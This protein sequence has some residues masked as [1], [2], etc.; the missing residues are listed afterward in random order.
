M[1]FFEHQERARRKTGLLVVYFVVAVAL[2]IVAVYL[3]VVAVL[4]YGEGGGTLWVPELFVVISAGTLAIVA[5]GSL[6]KI[7]ELSGGG[8]VVARALG[9]RP[10][11]PNTR[12]LRERVLL[13]VV[14]EMAIASGTPVPPVFLMDGERAI[15][16]FAAGTTPQNAVI[17][18]TRG[19]VDTLSRDELQGVIAHEFSHILNG[20]MRLNIRLIGLLSGILVIA[21]IGY[22]LMRTANWSSGLARSSDD[23]KGGNPLPV[24]GFCLYVI[25]YIGVF[26]GHLIKS[27]VSR[28]R[29]F[30][31]DAS[32]VQ[33]TRLPDGIAGALKKIGGLSAGSRLR[34]PQAE[35][36]S[37]MLFG[38]GL[39]NPFLGLL[40]TH[41][42]LEERIR[43][44]DPQFDGRFPKT[45][46]VEY[47]AADIV[48]T[49]SLAA[50][51]AAV[52][53][54]G[55]AT[56]P[57]AASLA[58][59]PEAAVAQIGAP[60]AQHL[61][62]A[63]ALVESLPAELA[64]SV[65]DP[66]GAVAVIYALLLND[67][68]ADVRRRQLEY[69]AGKADPRANREMLRLASLVTDLEPQAE[70]PLVSMVVPAL[71][72]LSPAQL[73]AFHDDV[74]YLVNADDKV[75]LFEYAVHL[76][77]AKRLLPRVEKRRTP[78]VRHDKLAP[79]A[80]A[81]SGLLSSLVSYGTRDATQAERAFA[82]GAEKLAADGTRVER[83]PASQCGL[84]AIDAALDQLAGAA[85]AIKK[86][87]IE[88]CAACIGA[89]GTITVEEG[90]LLRVICDSLDCP[91]PPL[92]GATD[93][94]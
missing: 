90:E 8:A 12:D 77:V 23:R 27:A 4:F 42:P 60:R 25:G 76:L 61:D 30:L 47:T 21:M 83:L 49:K 31:A 51:R 22:V 44:I 88:A 26:F 52:T 3:A 43:R 6:V 40:A 16:A 75:N 93:P 81:C 32:A 56:A 63:A 87:V 86:V 11:A 46:A 10:V 94:V 65:H 68:E 85:P 70:L 59:Q 38:N 66:L 9:G 17:G 67:H 33:F 24:L 34:A 71:D 5:I 41:P 92:L 80:P 39:R 2:I 37:H 50:R 64:R 19:T 20:D 29:E 78:R 15:N 57:L 55:A 84:K 35:E 72:A 1:D 36:A 69:L 48:D 13:N 73:A 82:L 28:Q 14:E 18:V 89:D 79:L 62:Y 45:Q 58:F 54:E 7:V 91:M 53:G 74:V